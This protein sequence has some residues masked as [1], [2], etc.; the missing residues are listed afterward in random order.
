[1]FGVIFSVRLCSWLCVRYHEFREA[2]RKWDARSWVRPGFTGG[3]GQGAGLGH[4]W[5]LGTGSH[6]ADIMGRPRVAAGP[7]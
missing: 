7:W 2:V 4:C 3:W 5:Q 6:E 1:M